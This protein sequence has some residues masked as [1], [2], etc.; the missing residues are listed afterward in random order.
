[1]VIITVLEFRSMNLDVSQCTEG[2]SPGVSNKDAFKV[3]GSAG[4][5]GCDPS[6]AVSL[7]FSLDVL[8]GM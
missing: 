8:A 1:M 2:D 5:A 6:I 4:C 7:T 3:P